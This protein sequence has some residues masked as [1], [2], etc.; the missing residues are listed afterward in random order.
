MLNLLYKILL[1]LSTVN[2]VVKNNIA[3]ATQGY[4]GI[5]H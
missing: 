2:E 3:S 4:L 5:A 1:I